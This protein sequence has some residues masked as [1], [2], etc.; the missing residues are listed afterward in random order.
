MITDKKAQVNAIL[1]FLLIAALVLIT[2][3]IVV[4]V[5]QPELITGKKSGISENKVK[6]INNEITCNSPYIEVGN[7]CC[8][9]SNYNLICDKDEAYLSQ[10]NICDLP[11]IEKN[12]V[13]CPDMNYNGVC[14]NQEV[15]NDYGY[16]EREYKI[17]R[18]HI[19]SPFHLS[20]PELYRDSISIEL[21][22]DGDED[23]MI[24]SI[25][26]E[27]CGFESVNKVLG[28]DKK[29]TFYIDCDS[30]I[31]RRVNSDLEVR[32]SLINNTDILTASGYIE[33]N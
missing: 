30:S 19:D 9:D 5:M 22:N 23:Y 27:H 21:R 17:T 25:D 11:Y 33:I 13:C 1:L 31:L 7:E 26:I 8:L 20:N 18:S 4:V 10:K 12:G 24:K 6:E 2:I 28:K 32:Y 29:K 15:T 14:D 16:G 3:V